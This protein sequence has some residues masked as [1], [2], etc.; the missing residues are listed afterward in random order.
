M[1]IIKSKN[2]RKAGSR[3]PKTFDNN[4][5]R[6]LEIQEMLTENYADMLVAVMQDASKMGEIV[7]LLE[8]DSHFAKFGLH[9]NREAAVAVTREIVN[10]GVIDQLLQNNKDI[11]DIGYNGRFLTIETNSEKYTYGLKDGEA[12]IDD[13]YIMK[14]VKR[15]ALREGEDGK[16]FSK[17]A[18]IF[19]GFSNNIRISATD[20]SLV[21]GGNITMS[22]RISRPKLVLTKKNWNNFADDAVYQLL[23]TLVKSHANIVISGETGTGKT[24]LLKMLVGA[25]PFEDKIIMI[26]DVA[27]THL[28]ELYPKKD[29]YSWLTTSGGDV[30]SSNQKGVTISDHIKN[31]LRNNPKWLMISETRGAEAYEMFQAVLSGHNLIT[32]LHSISNQAVPRRFVGMSS[33]GY[34]NVNEELL[35]EDFLSYIHLGIHIKK[36]IVNGR[37]FRFVDELS[38]FVPRSKAHP[39]GINMLYEQ[40]LS[41]DGIFYW[42]T[43]EQTSKLTKL[44]RDELDFD[45]KWPSASG[46]RYALD[47]KTHKRLYDGLH[48]G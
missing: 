46:T 29:I 13:A 25:I 24:E 14:I 43:H 6:L 8:K 44:V 45:L 5:E 41:E 37:V 26:E 3:G 30:A 47:P 28:A 31:A 1:A 23:M 21:A 40:R 16:N 34:P 38:E 11:T 7:N 4:K 10:L 39:N 2:S 20:P 27:E 17:G 12:K 9:N 18:P 19:N 33:I 22:L 15:F 36:K 32:T 35:E 48:K 42:K